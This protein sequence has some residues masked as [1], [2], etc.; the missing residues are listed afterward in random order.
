[1][2]WQSGLV[3]SSTQSFRNFDGILSGPVEQSLRSPRT[4]FLV[5]EKETS[6]IQKAFSFSG[7]FSIR[8]LRMLADLGFEFRSLCAVELKCLLRISGSALMLCGL[9]WSI[10]WMVFHTSFGRFEDSA[11]L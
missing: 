6:E 2:I 7:K 5:S 9:G 8:L 11:R 1:M 3:I 4:A 10:R